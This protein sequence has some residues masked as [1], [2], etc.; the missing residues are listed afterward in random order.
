MFTM[1]FIIGRHEFPLRLRLPL[2]LLFIGNNPFHALKPF[3]FRPEA[4]SFSRHRLCR[5]AADRAEC[6]CRFKLIG[7]RCSFLQTANL[8]D[9]PL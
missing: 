7:S 3:C 4:L 2:L 1:P 6:G 8:Q 9:P 5:Q